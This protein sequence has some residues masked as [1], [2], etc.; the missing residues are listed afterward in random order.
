MPAMKKYTFEAK[1]ESESGGGTYVLFPYDV[2]N[3]FG[4]KGRVPIQATFDGIP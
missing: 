2:E 1:I 4:V 3:E